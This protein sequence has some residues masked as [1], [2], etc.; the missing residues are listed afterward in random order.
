MQLTFF[1]I[2]IIIFVFF[3]IL[4]NGFGK[5]T[6]CSLFSL[7]IF[8]EL[9]ITKGYFL[10]IGDTEI[11]YILV[12]LIV[13]FIFSFFVIKKINLKFHLLPFALYIFSF[14]ISFSLMI[15]KPFNGLALTT[16]N[17]DEYFSYQIFKGI[18]QWNLYGFQY[19][20]FI[21]FFLRAYLILVYLSLA[22]NDKTFIL[23]R[24]IIYCFFG[25]IFGLIEFLEQNIFKTNN[26]YSLISRFFGYYGVDVHIYMYK[27]MGFYVI[28]GLTTEASYHSYAS[29]L[30]MIMIMTYKKVYFPIKKDIIL[31]H[32]KFLLWLSFISFILTFSMTSVF[33][34]VFLIGWY[35]CIYKFKK[36]NFYKFIYFLFI[37]ST[38]ILILNVPI[39]ELL[40][41]SNEI[42]QRIGKALNTILHLDTTNY[43]EYLNSEFVRF[44]SIYDTINDIVLNRPFFGL[45]LST[46]SCHSAVIND[47]LNYG[48]VGTILGVFFVSGKSF[49]FK[50]YHYSFTRL[51]NIIFLMLLIPFFV[52]KNSNIN[53]LYMSAIV[54]T[55]TSFVKYCKKENYIG[56]SRRVSYGI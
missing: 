2:F 25:V 3:Q 27:K 41:S 37:S 22:N 10:K 15:I 53:T 40:N 45:G 35:I 20:V 26:V 7:A 46:T 56:Y 33:I 19:G 47:I 49:Y 42:M 55:S 8:T 24:T 52:T 48:I 43:Y 50:N 31:K 23:N 29:A 17:W 1:S 30:L 38:M 5:K 32:Y 51:L 44:K 11:S 28:N 18:Y 34:G 6:F 21:G 14:L 13:V 12:I 39:E 16:G 9:N 54:Y 4:K 36:S